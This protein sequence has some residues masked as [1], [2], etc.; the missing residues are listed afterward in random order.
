LAAID[1]GGYAAGSLTYAL[2]VRQSPGKEAGLPAMRRRLYKRI[3]GG[4]SSS[5]VSRT[6]G[7]LVTKT[8]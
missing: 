4:D 3:P 2:S 7:E 6:G 5:L 1:P 8:S